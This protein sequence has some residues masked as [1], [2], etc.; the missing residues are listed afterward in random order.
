MGQK[1]VGEGSEREG[2]PRFKKR[3]FYFQENSLMAQ[4]GGG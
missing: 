1:V 2:K 4:E 3:N